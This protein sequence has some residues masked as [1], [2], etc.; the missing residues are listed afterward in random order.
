MEIRMK[1]CTVSA[2]LAA[3]LSFACAGADAQSP[4][5]ASGATPLEAIIADFAR[6]TGR[7]FIIDPR[8]QAQ[9][10]LAGQRPEDLDYGELL[11]VLQTHGYAAVERG[12]QVLI[13][14]DANVRQ[15]ASPIVAD[16][17]DYPDALFV[18]RVIRLQSVPASQL[19][20]VLRPLLP[21]HAHL[22]AF[23][24]TNA[25]LIVD[26]F[27]NVQRIERLARELDKGAPYTAPSCSPQQAAAEK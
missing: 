13:V 15:A 26:A 23:P 24:C 25:L 8:V 6:R 19:V 17:Q 2:L 16:G 4:A 1:R 9:V 21:Q 20:P 10:H 22:V 27:A 14:P 7:T 12:E 3:F 18:T 11:T 5:P